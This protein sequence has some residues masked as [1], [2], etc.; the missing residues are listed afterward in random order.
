MALHLIQ[1]KFGT[2]FYRINGIMTG[3]QGK[4]I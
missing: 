2:T 1:A 3:E 4:A